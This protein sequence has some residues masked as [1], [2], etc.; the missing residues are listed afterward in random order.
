MF[1]HFNNLETKLM[2][3]KSSTIFRELELKYA[4]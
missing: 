4:W 3:K 1:I 2:Y